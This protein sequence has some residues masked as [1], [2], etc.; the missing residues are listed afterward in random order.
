[1]YG[2]DFIASYVV[3]N[4]SE[5]S[6]VQAFVAWA[7]THAVRPYSANIHTNSW[8]LS[9]YAYMSVRT[10]FIASSCAVAREW[11]NG[12]YSPCFAPIRCSRQ[13]QCHSQTCIAR[14][15]LAAEP[16]EA[17]SSAARLRQPQPWNASPMLLYGRDL[18]RHHTRPLFGRDKGVC[19]L[20][21]RCTN[22]MLSPRAQT[23]RMQFDSIAAP[24]KK[25]PALLQ[26]RLFSLGTRGHAPLFH[27]LDYFFSNCSTN[28]L[29]S[30]TCCFSSSF[31]AFNSFMASTNTGTTEPYSM[32]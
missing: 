21:S 11:D 9:I 2:R 18:S 10:R 31:S 7:R 23:A 4:A 28:F 30:S 20:V 12:S 13:R 22:T 26:G 14:F 1:M 15:W 32:L 29:S 19:R 5:R 17:K 25:R 8:L 6:W 16:A 24:R 3:A 27:V